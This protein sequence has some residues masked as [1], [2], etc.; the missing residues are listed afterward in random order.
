MGPKLRYPTAQLYCRYLGSRWPRSGLL[1]KTCYAA[2]M[3]HAVAPHS[4]TL[5]HATNSLAYLFMFLL[6][7]PPDVL[8]DK[9]SNI[10]TMILGA[11]LY[12]AFRSLTP[13][14]PEVPPCMIPYRGADVM[15]AVVFVL[16]TCPRVAPGFFSAGLL[17]VLRARCCSDPRSIC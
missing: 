16:A 8:I 15:Y 1:A 17:T 9:L 3:R 7:V 5:P 13:G 12:T 11:P 6:V 2:P 4:L 14:A 10:R